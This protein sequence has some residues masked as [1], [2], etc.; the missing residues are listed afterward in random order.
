MNINFQL[1]EIQ[2]FWF[3]YK[4]FF[5]KHR[6]DLGGGSGRGIWEGDLGGGSWT[7]SSE[8]EQNMTTVAS[9]HATL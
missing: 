7:L 9:G 5:K 6:E 4:F 2:H 1:P 8:L 3:A